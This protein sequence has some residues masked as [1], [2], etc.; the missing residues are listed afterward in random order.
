M[1]KSSQGSWA[2]VRPYRTG[3]LIAGPSLLKSSQG[4]WARV[5]P[6]AHIGTLAVPA[7]A[8]LAAG[9]S[10]FNLAA[11]LASGLFNKIFGGSNEKP[12]VSP[13]TTDVNLG[14][15]LYP[16]LMGA[17]LGAGGGLLYN[18]LFGD[19]DAD[20]KEKKQHLRKSLMVGALL[21]T[22]AGIGPK[23]LESS[24]PQK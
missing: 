13:D 23:L 24:K 12:N 18:M 3:G 2:R 8:G 15:W 7:G 1:L 19:E 11:D 20:E 16:G 17:G 6:Y 4:F 5:R 22:L 9:S 21:G 14:E 10:L